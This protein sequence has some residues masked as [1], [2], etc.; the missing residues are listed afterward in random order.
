MTKPLINNDLSKNKGQIVLEYIIF[1]LCLCVIALRATFTEALNPHAAI[2]SGGLTNTVYSLVISG[3]LILLFLIWF[4]VNFSAGKFSYRRTNLELGIYVFV[5]ASILSGL[6]AANKRLTITN[7]VTLLAPILMAF[8]LVQILN[9]RSRIKLLLYVIATLG[10]VSTYQCYEQFHWNR[11]QIKFY[12]QNPEAVLASQGISPNSLKQWQY[13]HRLYSKDIRGF[14]TT[15]NSAGSFAI[16]ASFAAMALVLEKFKN[17]KDSHINTGKLIISSAAG[18]VV[19]F[20]LLLTKSKGAITAGAISAIMFVTYLCFGKQLK[21][22]KKAILITCSL[23]ALFITAAVIWFGSTYDKLPG[24]NSMLVRWQY[25]QASAKMSADSFPL[26]VG[27]GN[28]ATFYT[29]YKPSAALETVSDPHNFILSLLSQY[30]IAGLL[31]F[32]ALFLLPLSKI[33]NTNF[34]TME[35]DSRTISLRTKITLLIIISAALLF[36]RPILMPMPADGTSQQIAAAALILYI[37]P[38]FVF[39]AGFALLITAENKTQNSALTIAALFCAV[40]GVLIHNLI[41]FAIFEPAVYTT[42]WAV[43]ACLI[44]ANHHAKSTP[45]IV[46][47]PRFVSKLLV[48]LISIAI[49]SAYLNY[50]FVPVV[51]AGI[52]IQDAMAK[53]ENAHQLLDAAAKDDPFDPTALNIN[54]TLYL[55]RYRQSED[56]N[57]SL[58]A[59]AE[60]CFK[61]AIVR[62][63]ADYSYYE[64]LADVYTRY[65]ETEEQDNLTEAFK[66]MS[67][68]IRCYPNSA[69]LRIKSAQ[70]SEKMN[71]TEIAVSQYRKA[72]K[73]EDDY[74]KQ[75]K[76]LYPEHKV[77][78]RLGQEKYDMAKQRI[79]KLSKELK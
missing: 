36:I 17:R 51:K 66:Y 45:Y 22:Y 53:P 33:V 7:I 72:V 48:V 32:I 28:F 56:R 12:E 64:K 42:L 52:K 21:K 59:K 70:L 43:M 16:L 30:G 5:I 71:N 11:E 6:A 14:F 37:M 31:G 35:D 26:G 58:L 9:S 38:V 20:G 61:A 40:V 44:A 19:I 25:W 41:D 1:G 54:G 62:N 29:H 79:E 49:V 50:A 63:S 4:W 15:S 39:I 60:D 8:I 18:V 13:E 68:A 69:R 23:L 67:H 34:V 47:Q 2:R 3:V 75:F 76:M 10:I 77:F 73:I 55:Q 57:H 74:R 65:N 27:P 24:G 78:S 46:K